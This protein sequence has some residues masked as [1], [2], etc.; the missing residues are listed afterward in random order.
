MSARLVV[1]MVK[2]VTSLKLDILLGGGSAD[3]IPQIRLTRYDWHDVIN[4]QQATDVHPFNYVWGLP[5]CH[6]PISEHLNN[7][8]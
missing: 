4:G 6:I 3:T 8:I 1:K 5:D 7:Y 2:V